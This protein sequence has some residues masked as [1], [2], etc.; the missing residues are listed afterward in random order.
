MSTSFAIA[1]TDDGRLSVRMSGKL[2][3][4]VAR[5][6]LDF[7]KA[8]VELGKQEI[9]LDL[10][11]VTS[12]DSIGVSIFNWI[13]SRNGTLKVDVAPPLAGVS[14]DELEPITRIIT[15][16]SGRSPVIPAPSFI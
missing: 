2:T 7:L 6:G 13:L 8:A 3:G 14:D 12:L 10:R 15:N 1:F 11:E 4:H 16:N 5:E 9:K